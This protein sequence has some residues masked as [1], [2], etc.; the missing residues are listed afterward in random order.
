M[1]RRSGMIVE[2]WRGLERA[3]GH[4]DARAAVT[5]RMGGDYRAALG[6]GAVDA[7]GWPRRR[8]RS[9]V[10]CGTGARLGG[11]RAAQR[12]SCTAHGHLPNRSSMYN[13]RAPQR[14]ARAEHPTR[15]GRRC[16]AAGGRRR[17]AIAHRVAG[18]AGRRG[19]AFDRRWRSAR[20][21][22][23]RRRRPACLARAGV[24]PLRRRLGQ[25]R[26]GAR[27]PG[28]RLSGP[29]H[30]FLGAGRG[31]S[32]AAEMEVGTPVHPRRARWACAAPSP[33]ALLRWWRVLLRTSPTHRRR[34]PAT[35][36]PAGCSAHT[37]T[38][39]TPSEGR[40]PAS[41]PSPP[42]DAVAALRTTYGVV[43]SDA[44]SAYAPMGRVFGRRTPAASTRLALLS[45][46]RIRL[47][48]RPA[49][50][51]MQGAL[52]LGPPARDART[53]AR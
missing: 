24:S 3:E 29:P 45:P 4:Q 22:A 26:Q 20:S 6:H 48:T 9:A 7:S 17:L 10:A 21:R 15:L 34:P 2:R 11:S 19:I 53:P 40:R 51:D 1:G 35:S 14:G 31:A 8:M 36:R 5:R 41:S 27:M 49:A 25:K 23:A 46:L 33:G 18:I 43:V 37:H 12:P 32:G 42:G 28:S 47:P 16:R 13:R 39:S 50:L 30:E 52:P 44:T 38:S